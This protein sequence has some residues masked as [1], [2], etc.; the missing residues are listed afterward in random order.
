MRQSTRIASWVVFA[1]GTAIG[2]AWVVAFDCIVAAA[3]LHPIGWAMALA[4]IATL[5]AFTLTP[6]GA[7]RPHARWAACGALLLGVMVILVPWNERKRF[8][9]DLHS[10]RAGMSVDEVEAVMGG[11]IKGMGAQWELPL[12]PD[13]FGHGADE[14]HVADAHAAARAAAAAYRAPEFPTG[15]RRAHATG[16]MTYRW[17]VTEYNADW[18]QVEFVN[19][20][21]VNIA[22]WPD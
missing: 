21:V 12:G 11:Y 9:H 8:L 4:P 16:T 17:N 15:A 22:F 3:W 2:V 10:V 18:G 19:G 1:I 14:P 5:A 7:T 13:P 20:K 6:I